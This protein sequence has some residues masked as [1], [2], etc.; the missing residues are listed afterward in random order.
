M[1]TSKLQVLQTWLEKCK[2]WCNP[3]QP[4][5][6][7]VEKNALQVGQYIG[8]SFTRFIETVNIDLHVAI[9]VSKSQVCID[10]ALPL[11]LL[12]GFQIF[13]H[14][15]TAVSAVDFLQLLG[16]LPTTS[17]LLPIPRKN[18]GEQQNKGL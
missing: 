12:E 11:V 2:L 7:F 17:F 1:S 16:I 15:D 9:V 3:S 6:V 18:L 10:I 5:R 13:Q 4:P 8:L 14:L